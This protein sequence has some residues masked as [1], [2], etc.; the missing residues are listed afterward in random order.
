MVFHFERFCTGL[1]IVCTKGFKLYFKG[2]HPLTNTKRSDFMEM[3][4]LLTKYIG[5]GVRRKI[6]LAGTTAKM[7]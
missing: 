2:I 6:H 7:Q 1:L 5:C 3:S 4:T